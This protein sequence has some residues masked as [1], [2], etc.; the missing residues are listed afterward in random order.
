M[1]AHKAMAT[2]WQEREAGILVR[3][4]EARA[5]QGR[6]ER[7]WDGDGFV[8]AVAAIN[9]AERELVQLNLERRAAGL[10]G[11]GR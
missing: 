2:D 11:S 4:A 3:L 9:R 1:G 7:D 8:S 10:Y 5:Q 6:A